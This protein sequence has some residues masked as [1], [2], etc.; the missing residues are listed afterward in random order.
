MGI[1][2]VTPVLFASNVDDV[3][4]HCERCGSEERRSV[5]RG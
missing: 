1:K 3:I 5:R 4:Y 2:L